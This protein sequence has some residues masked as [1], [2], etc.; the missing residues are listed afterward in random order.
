MGHFFAAVAA[1]DVK[2]VTL[3]AQGSE[4]I[5][6]FRADGVLEAEFGEEGAIAAEDGVGRMVGRG[7]VGSPLRSWVMPSHAGCPS[8]QIVL[9]GIGIEQAAAGDLLDGW[10]SRIRAGDPVAAL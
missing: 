10:F 4:G 9:L 6:G 2:R 3:A 8:V 1:E 7:A 5:P